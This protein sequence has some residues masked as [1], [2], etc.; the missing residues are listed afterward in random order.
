MRRLAALALVALASSAE[1]TCTTWCDAAAHPNL[2]C[3]F[4]PSLSKV[5][6]YFHGGSDGTSAGGDPNADELVLTVDIPY[7][8]TTGGNTAQVALGKPQNEAYNNPNNANSWEKRFSED[9]RDQTDRDECIQSYRVAVPWPELFANANSEN[10]Y[11]QLIKNEDRPYQRGYFGLVVVDIKIPNLAPVAP[12][13][14]ADWGDIDRQT[15]TFQIPYTIDFPNQV[16]ATVELRSSTGFGS[17]QV[18]VSGM[19]ATATPT[20]GYE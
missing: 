4:P 12:P 6:S 3:T 7:Q 17:D 10:G 13:A 15:F 1:P 18:A 16:S 20:D 9:P 14:H 19:Q 5:G 8:Y 2:E 11:L